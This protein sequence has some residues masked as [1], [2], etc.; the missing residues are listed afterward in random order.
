MEMRK[1]IV[2][3]IYSNR[4]IDNKVK[5]D[6]FLGNS[7]EEAI[8]MDDNKIIEKY[9]DKIDQDRREQEQR[10]SNNIQ[11][12]EN[13]LFEDRKLM[14]QR[15]TEERRLSEERM[16]KRFNEAIESIK[17]TNHKIDSLENK[18]D[19]KTDKMLEKVDSTNKWIMGTCIATILAV[20][21]IAVSAWFK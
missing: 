9:M 4:N 19:D 15:I 3:E 20:A 1:A 16:E 14:E 8:D 13:R 7:C 6:E 2:T 11:S 12:M 18:L 10:L 5:I 17:N 21:A